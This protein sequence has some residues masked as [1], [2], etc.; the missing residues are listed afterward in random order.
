MDFKI[1][2][3]IYTYISI[4]ICEILP[5]LYKAGNSAICINTIDEP[6]AY[7]A[8]FKKKAK[9]SKTNTPGSQFHVKS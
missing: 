7:Y 6:G 3:Y 5:I 8:K 9:P 2:E 4:W 1:A